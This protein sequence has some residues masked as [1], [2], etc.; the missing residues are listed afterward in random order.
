MRPEHLNRRISKTLFLYGL[1]RHVMFLANVNIKSTQI[2]Y[3]YIL[4]KSCLRKSLQQIT[5]QLTYSP[6]KGVIYFLFATI[7]VCLLCPL[8]F[9]CIFLNDILSEIKES[10]K[11]GLLVTVPLHK[12]QSTWTTNPHQNQG[13][14][15]CHSYLYISLLSSLR[16]N[17]NKQW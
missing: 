11:C 10:V 5:L 6:H 4:I 13:A 2:P 16:A 15:T 12:G 3:T 8:C 14:E 9:L 7:T 17:E 1:F